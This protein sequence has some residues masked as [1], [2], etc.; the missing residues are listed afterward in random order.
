MSLSCYLM[1]ANN[2]GDFVV[3]ILDVG[4]AGIDLFGPAGKLILETCIAT[5]AMISEAL[6]SKKFQTSF[7]IERAYVSYYSPGE[8]PL[9]LK[10]DHSVNI[11]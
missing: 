6:E 5:A 9:T 10:P 8:S 4:E 1:H 7:N 2:L 11:I 3:R